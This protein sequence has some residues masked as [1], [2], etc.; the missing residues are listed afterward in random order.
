MN[1]PIA[2]LK[3]ICLSIS[4]KKIEHFWMKWQHCFRQLD[5][6]KSVKILT[7]R[8]NPIQ[9]FKIHSNTSNTSQFVFNRSLPHQLLKCIS[10]KYYNNNILIL[11]TDERVMHISLWNAL[12][13]KYNEMT[14]T[15]WDCLVS[16]QWVNLKTSN[17][18]EKKKQIIIFHLEKAV[19]NKKSP[20]ITFGHKNWL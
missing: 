7:L 3:I 16:K 18:Q 8:S 11:I 13:T 1:K 20:S 6:L 4:K 10:M 2:L 15:A 5:M 19:I 17:F 14:C 12:R 9:N